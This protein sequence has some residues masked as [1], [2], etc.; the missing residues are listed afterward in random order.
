MTQ[1]F[2]IILLTS[3]G[4]LFWLNL[5][6]AQIDSLSHDDIIQYYENKKTVTIYLSNKALKSNNALLF[7]LSKLDKNPKGIPIN[8]REGGKLNSVLS[9][10]IEFAENDETNYN[11]SLST[12]VAGLNEYSGRNPRLNSGDSILVPHISVIV[13][14]MGESAN[15][16]LGVHYD[17]LKGSASTYEMTERVKTGKIISKE[18]LF[19]SASFISMDIQN[20]NANKF[21]TQY[22]LPGLGNGT[23]Y[24][25]T[26]IEICPIELPGSKINSYILPDL[27]Q[28]DAEVISEIQ[29]IDT[30]VV[31]DFYFFDSF[32]TPDQGC[33]HGESVENIILSILDYFHAPV[34]K[35]KVKSVSL[36]FFD[37]R[38]RALEIISDYINVKYGESDINERLDTKIRY[39]RNVRRGTCTGLCMPSDYLNIL[40][41]Y[42]LMQEPEIISMSFYMKTPYP[43]MSFSIN[44]TM[45]TNLLGA[46]MN[47]IGAIEE[48]DTDFTGRMNEPMYTL[49]SNILETG[50]MLVGAESEVGKYN[51]LYSKEGLY[52]SAL[53]RGY[54][55]LSSGCSPDEYGTSWATPEIATKLFIAKAYW[56][57]IGL[58]IDA[59]EAKRRLL[60]SCD[61]NTNFVNKFASPGIPNMNKLLRKD[62]DGFIEKEVEIGQ[63]K[64]VYNIEILRN[65]PKMIIDSGDDKIPL[66][67]KKS[68]S[69]LSFCGL[70]YESDNVYVFRESEMK[71]ELL[72]DLFDS[73]FTNSNIEFKNFK[74]LLLNSN[75]IIDIKTLEDLRSNNINQIVV[76]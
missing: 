46:V 5:S 43:V 56:T 42:H 51:C 3:L 68:D 21:I 58:N 20:E 39:Y 18:A 12:F 71:W 66:K 30:T 16:N 34:L 59:F 57:S 6:F 17:Y 72:N 36:D 73:D 76:L 62:D 11:D 44:P 28:I 23:I 53:G 1:R 49:K 22:C 48:L 69:I 45:R 10:E 52:V 61:L 65:N 4:L 26:G 54:W 32:Q 60:L 15:K 13:K 74:I 38:D 55:N 63:E 33:A 8:V 2:T 37:N 64:K 29:K 35:Q 41:D 27:E 31:N 19:D 50:T 7:G 9:N 40:L 25:E 70:Y 47:N 67:F 75:E 14:E 24:V